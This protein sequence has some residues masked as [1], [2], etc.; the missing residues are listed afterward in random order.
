MIG[1]HRFPSVPIGSRE[2]VPVPTPYRGGEPVPR[3]VVPEGGNQLEG[4]G[5]LSPDGWIQEGARNRSPVD[6]ASRIRRP[7]RATPTPHAP[8]PTPHAP[9]LARPRTRRAP[10]GPERPARSTTRNR[11][12]PRHARSPTTSPH[13]SAHRTRSPLL[14]SIDAARSSFEPRRS[15]PGLPRAHTQ[16][17]RILHLHPGRH[18]STRAIVPGPCSPRHPRRHAGGLGDRALDGWKPGFPWR[19]REEG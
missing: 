3:P 17:R 19:S 5:R 18:A 15:P 10:G 6:L 7:A 14:P 16:G 8:R 1:S 13:R 11:R 4:G 9:P 12:R 2:L